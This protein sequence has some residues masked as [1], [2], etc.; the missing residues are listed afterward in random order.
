MVDPTV[1]AA[2]MEHMW[3]VSHP[4]DLVSLLEL[5]QTHGA[6][7]RQVVGVFTGGDVGENC[8]GEHLANQGCRDGPGFERN[9]VGSGGPVD[10]WVEE[11]GQTHDP[12]EG[13]DESPE[14]AEEGEGVDE[15]F[16]EE[17]FCVACWEPHFL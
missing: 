3:A 6:V 5:V 7:L 4:S 1:Y 15:E 11:F 2:P 12:E 17:D 9:W 14:K 8:D 10:I 13:E 16:W